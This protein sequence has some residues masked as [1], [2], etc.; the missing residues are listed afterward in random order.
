MDQNFLPRDA[1]MRELQAM[2]SVIADLIPQGRQVAYLD[3]ALTTNLGDLLIVLGT[4][5]F[6][7]RYN[8][9]RKFS[10]NVG[11][12]ESDDRLPIGKDDIIVLHG[13]GNFGDIYP[14]FQAY[15]ERII[16]KFTDNQIVVM[17]QT[18]HFSSPEKLARAC[19]KMNKHPN[20]TFFVRDEVS[21][22]LTKPYFGERV[23]LMP[24]MAH[25]LW[26]SLLEEVRP[27]S[28]DNG[29]LMLM[30]TDVEKTTVP[31]VIGE[32]SSAFTDWDNYLSVRYRAEKR[33][34]NK[35]SAAR[36]L[37][38]IIGDVDEHYFKALHREIVKVGSTLNDNPV[39]ITSRLHGAILGFLI[40]K[41]VVAID[42]SYGKLS[43]YIGAW[44]KQLGASVVISDAD[45]AKA[46]MDFATS[47]KGLDRTAVWARYEELAQRVG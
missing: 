4:L 13:G 17:P 43:S 31:G 7:D 19:E 40:G 16:E 14:H 21:L 32:Q 47:S 44:K 9:K 46:A 30:R 23:K 25:Q 35:I 3:Y 27:P 28:V 39:W 15:R 10:R 42:N 33:L 11:N 8:I 24:D 36:P 20:I 12:S 22:G 1:G 37:S 18:V 29:P 34:V 41:P 26:P 38:N 45:G 2:H 5:K 6:F